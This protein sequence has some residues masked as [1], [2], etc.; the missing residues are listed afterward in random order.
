MQRVYV[1]SNEDMSKIVCLDKN[2]KKF[3]LLDIKDK[4]ALNRAMSFPNLTAAKNLQQRIESYD[5]NFHK[6]L[7]NNVAQLYKNSFF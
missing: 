3:M 6:T 5:S 7:I 4:T 1:L 2:K